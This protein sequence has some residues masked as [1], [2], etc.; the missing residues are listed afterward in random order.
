ME[1][2]KE[3]LQLR[4]SNSGNKCTRVLGK[5]EDKL[6]EVGEKVRQLSKMGKVLQK[7]IGDCR[8]RKASD[9]CP[10][11]ECCEGD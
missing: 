3:L 7:L 2:I 11:L 8:Q 6:K 4:S 1:E 5:A 10:I 9:S